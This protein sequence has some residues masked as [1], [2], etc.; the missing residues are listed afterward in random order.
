MPVESENSQESLPE[1]VVGESVAERVDWTVEVAE[2]V[3]D[4]VQQ[5]RDATVAAEA[6]D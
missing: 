2:P 3:R 5:V 6:D 4:I 1:L